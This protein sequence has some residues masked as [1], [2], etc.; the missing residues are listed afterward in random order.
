MIIT[1]SA[2]EEAQRATEK[3]QRL[4]QK[5]DPCLTQKGVVRAF[6]TPYFCGKFFINPNI[7]VSMTNFRFFLKNVA[8]IVACFAVC[9]MF[10]ACDETKPEDEL[11]KEALFTAF[12][13][14]G[15]EGA[16]TINESASTIT[17][18]ASAT[19]DLTKI[20]PIFSVS[21][22]AT[23]SVN[24]VP[25]VSGV[26]MNNFTN[27]VIYSVISEDT[28]TNKPWTVT[29]T[30]DGGKDPDQPGDKAL[31]ETF[32][33]DGIEGTATITAASP[34]TIV[35]KASATTDLTTIKPS[36]TVSKGATVTVNNVTQVSGTTVNDFTNPVVYTVKSEDA[37]T[38]T[39]WTVTITKDVIN[40]G[41]IN[42]LTNAMINASA[43]VTL[44]P[45]YYQ[46][47]NNLTLNSGNTLTFSPG[48]V[49]LFDE[50]RRLEA[51]SNA[52]IIANGTAAQ[53][54]TFTSSN[55]SPAAGDWY[56]IYI[57]QNGSEFSW[58]VF[59]YGSGQSSGWGMLY[60]DDCK[61]SVTNCVFRNSKYSGIYLY[62]AGSGLTTFNNNTMSD[63]GETDAESYP[64]KVGTSA[65]LSGI[66]DMGENVITTEKGIGVSGG[67]IPQNVTIKSYVDYLFYGSQTI[68]NTAVLT[69]EAGATLKFDGN[70]LNV[71][72]GAK[73]TADG[74]AGTI[75]FTSAKTTNI[76]AGDWYGVYIN[77][78]N[79]SEFKNCLFEYGAGQSSGWGMIYLDDSK[80]SFT[81]CTFRNAKY[82]GIYLY[83]ASSGFTTFDNNTI[84]DCGETD[85]DSYPINVGTSAN[86]SGIGDMGYNDIT[87]A[88]GIG[89]SSGTIPRNTT[90]KSY[91]DYLFYGDQ[92]LN[93][94]AELTIEAGSTLKF[95]TD[96]QMDV[97]AGAKIIA[98]GTT[99]APITFTSAKAT[100][101]GAGDWYGIYFDS[102][103]S[104]FNY[105]L[106]EYGAG[107]S[108][109]WGMIYL[110]DCKAGFTNCTFRDAKYNGI[111][112]Y[113]GSSGF[114]TFDNNT[115]SAC[116]EDEVESYPIK[117][118][119][120]AGMMSLSVMGANNTINSAKG[121]GISGTVSG[122][123]TLRKYLYTVY[124]NISINNSSSSATLTILPGAKLMFTQNLHL[125]IER[126]GKLVAQGTAADKIIFTGTVQNKG[127]WDGIRF[128]NSDALDGNLLDHCEI[129]Y[130]GHGTSSDNNGNISCY[131]IGSTKLTVTNC[132]L[133]Y[134][135]SW[136]IWVYS[137]ANPNIGTGNTYSN[138][139]PSDNSG[140]GRAS[141]GDEAIGPY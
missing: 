105:C 71:N 40:P 93:N 14:T 102:N 140:L 94:A 4:T 124:D 115:M 108:S 47:K 131:G 69:I 121:I 21:K 136:G 42:E 120:S 13:F 55:V 79:N 11:G 135:R 53:T 83:R 37:E 109:G 12:T 139:G 23:V 41:D 62:R 57:N 45:G 126:G 66:G 128:N 3:I 112:L 20:T 141:A 130:G 92:T 58:C 73:I 116:G 68:N 72:A 125:I 34:A 123:L 70:Q 104:V 49:I 10:S 67:I 61:A 17:A 97:N 86:L 18:K 9:M 98:E 35:A 15:I 24:N 110:D 26:T 119:T 63:C 122:N 90:I 27:S 87:T 101:Q 43:N 56:G 81:N 44:P 76:G 133:T 33:F 111:Y 129:S 54:I 134:S 30:Q 38:T 84:I 127:W 106:F 137:N 36:F 117:A 80:A 5:G 39:P 19:T 85:A 16:A 100:N 28:K 29:I 59:E 31:F 103:N 77:S 91:V 99:T 65:N 118:G 60:L 25:Q 114:T 96:R 138:N 46:V 95:G 8:T 7:N 22:G 2:T 132:N 78:S 50:D 113:R 52:K 107:Q 74:T 82:N 48:T 51:E 75:T 1:Q 6:F 64:I 89:V 32:T 88:K